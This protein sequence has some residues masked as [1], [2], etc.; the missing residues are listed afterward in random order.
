MVGTQPRL[1]VVGRFPV[2]GLLIKLLA[3]VEQG[4]VPCLLVE[5]QH[6]EDVVAAADSR[7]GGQL[8]GLQRLGLPREVVLQ[9][10][11][12]PLVPR[13]VIVQLQ[14]HEHGH[15]GPVVQLFGVVCK[16]TEGTAFN[17]T[18]Q[19][20]VDPLPGLLLH[21]I[22]VQHV[23]RGDETAGIV[24]AP[25][26]ALARAAKPARTVVP[27]GLAVGG[28]R[29]KLLG[30]VFGLEEQLI[31]Q[32][33]CGL[34]LPQGER[35]K[36]HVVYSSFRG[37][38]NVPRLAEQ[39]GRLGLGLGFG[40]GSRGRGCGRFCI[41]FMDVRGGVAGCHASRTGGGRQHGQGEQQAK[42]A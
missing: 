39:D 32:P 24:G 18:F 10:G 30:H 21:V 19:R 12:H 8:F 2:E 31:P 42:Y 3:E 5:P 6:R 34:H 15:E 35:R 33:A 25:L 9:E 16:G 7:P 40:A 23:G 17:L 28:Q 11:D 14:S 37:N 22:I 38:E 4:F 13:G 26:P 27:L 1:L 20:P 41:G 36:F 29:L